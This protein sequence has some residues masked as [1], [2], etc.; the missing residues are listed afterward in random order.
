M[1]V[2]PY[3]WSNPVVLKSARTRLDMRMAATLEDASGR[4]LADVSSVDVGA[5]Q[6]IDRIFGGMTAR[7]AF[8]VVSGEGTTLLSVVRPARKG[9]RDRLENLEVR[10]ASGSL[11]GTLRQANGYLSGRRC[12]ELEVGSHVIGRTK[13]GSGSDRIE[14]EDGAGRSLA[15]VGATPQQ[16]SVTNLYDYT[17]NMTG[18]S[19]PSTMWLCLAAAIAEYFYDRIDDGGP[20]RALLWWT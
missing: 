6:R 13:R 19:D 8:E 20:M 12:F 9:L 3:R 15:I 17:V 18:A 16:G 11:V 5:W 7:Y 10:D 14:L 2:L 1:A 4:L